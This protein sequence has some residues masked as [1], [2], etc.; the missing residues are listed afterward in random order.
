MTTTTH[1]LSIGDAAVDGLFRGVLAGVGMAAY[2][3]LALAPQGGNPASVLSLFGPSGGTN[4]TLGTVTHLAVSAIYGALFGALW[5]KLARRFNRPM[6]AVIGG[7]VYSG[8]LFILAESVLL[9]A[10]QSPLASIPAL[11]FGIGHV[12]YGLCLGVLTERGRRA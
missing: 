7:L 3:M 6:L 11:Q 4:P 2:L 12:V 9:N 5:Q 1:K 8:L 10:A